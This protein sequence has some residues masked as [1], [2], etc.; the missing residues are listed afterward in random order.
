MKQQETGQISTL[1][2]D[3]HS[4]QRRPTNLGCIYYNS[5]TEELDKSLSFCVLFNCTTVFL[6][7]TV[8]NSLFFKTR[9]RVFNWQ[10]QRDESSSGGSEQAIGQM[11]AYS[12]EAD[13]YSVWFKPWIAPAPRECETTGQRPRLDVSVILRRGYHDLSVNLKKKRQL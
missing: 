11:T 7:A 6:V 9:L 8:R 4:I 1:C 5:S 3:P 10:A 13:D 12:S 2:Q